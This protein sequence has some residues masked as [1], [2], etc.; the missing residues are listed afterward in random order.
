MRHIG[1]FSS[2][3]LF[4]IIFTIN[5]F[6]WSMSSGVIGPIGLIYKQSVVHHKNTMLDYCF[7]IVY[8]A[9]PTSIQHR[10]NVTMI[11]RVYIS[12]ILGFITVGL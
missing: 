9:G 3:L 8:H 4:Y 12:D 11:A 2:Y 5:Y 6:L 7:L 10:V 1:F